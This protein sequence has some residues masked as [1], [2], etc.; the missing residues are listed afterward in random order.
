ERKFFKE[1]T[2]QSNYKDSLAQV[3]CC[4]GDEFYL[5][6]MQY[7]HCQKIYYDL[8]NLSRLLSTIPEAEAEV[9]GLPSTE[10][11]APS[12][13]ILWDKIV[14][15]EYCGYEHVYDIE[16]DGTHNFIGNGIFAHNTFTKSP[17]PDVS[18]LLRF[19]EFSPD[20]FR[21]D[22][23]M[24]R[25]IDA[26]VFSVS[27]LESDSD[28]TKS[29][30]ALCI[31]TIARLM[32]HLGI[33]PGDRVIEFGPG[34]FSVPGIV[35]SFLEAQFLGIEIESDQVKEL[36]EATAHLS[37][38]PHYEHADAIK[39]PLESGAYQVAIMLGVFSPDLS[40]EA[41]RDGFGST[42]DEQRQLV[43]KALDALEPGGRLAIGVYP[44][45]DLEEA[46]RLITEVADKQEITVERDRRFNLPVAGYKTAVFIVRKLSTTESHISGAKGAEISSAEI[47]ADEATDVSKGKKTKAI[48][49]SST[50]VAQASDIVQ[51]IAIEL[52]RTGEEYR[53]WRQRVQQTLKELEMTKLQFVKPSMAQ[54]IEGAVELPLPGLS[55]LVYTCMSPGR[56]EKDKGAA[57][58]AY[59]KLC[60]LIASSFSND[61]EDYSDKRRRSIGIHGLDALLAEYK[62]RI[63]IGDLDE[64]Y[65]DAKVWEKA[66]NDIMAGK[67][68]IEVPRV[69]EGIEVRM[70]A[71][72]LR[73][74]RGFHILRLLYGH[75]IPKLLE[76]VYEQA[77]Q[78][79]LEFDS[80][81]LL[82]KL[83]EKA[84]KIEVLREEWE[85]D[86]IA[87]AAPNDPKTTAI[88]I[89]GLENIL[90][91]LHELVVQKSEAGGD[92]I[93]EPIVLRDIEQANEMLKSGQY[94]IAQE[95]LSQS[96]EVLEGAYTAGHFEG[97][98]TEEEYQEILRLIQDKLDSVTPPAARATAPEEEV[99][100]INWTIAKVGN[101]DEIYAEEALKFRADIVSH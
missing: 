82:G 96:V 5:F 14:S 25:M 49:I 8:K 81:K 99:A 55:H 21:K 92:G 95:F 69:P 29:W 44:F 31:I 42:P 11:R 28:P 63:D 74:W 94:E 66:V 78:L 16:V 17:P 80:N 86:F 24:R 79:C 83:R 87:R 88:S 70:E 71:Q 47:K 27:D 93:I 54:D 12:T 101:F 45:Q 85:K 39:Y 56:T 97:I 75:I 41:S 59:K 9:Q 72:G 33:K 57:S 58:S 61:E 90:K 7:F 64:A 89:L 34:H 20:L 76:K 30:N 73:L 3:G 43:Q 60:D 68:E 36:Q 15:I 10:H 77:Q 4:F 40:P 50:A 53:L 62:G 1:I 65:S 46:I 18:S 84:E 100:L 13:A 22:E 98:I 51:H 38:R 35:A 23:L 19:W 32:R 6:F 26:G 48:P 91:V 2:C 37:P 52:G 67:E